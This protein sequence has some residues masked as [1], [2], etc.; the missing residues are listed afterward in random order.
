MRQFLLIIF[1]IA[2][3]ATSGCSYRPPTSII[4]IK[5]S[6][7]ML[8][9]TERLAEEFMKNNPGVSIYV[10]G[11][12]TTSGIRA[13]TRGQVHISTAS[14]KIRPEEIKEIAENYQVLGV[15]FLIAKDALSIYLNKNNPVRNLSLEQVRDIF[16]CRTNNWSALGGY[17]MAI[18]PVIRPPNSGT[19]AYIKKFVLQDE[20]YC[21]E[22][23]IRTSTSAVTET[24]A[25]SPGAIGYGG[26]AFHK[27]IEHAKING[28]APT[29]ENVRNDK[30]PLVRYLHFYTLNTPEGDVKKFIDWTLSPEG[31][32]IVKKSGYIPLWSIPF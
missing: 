15:S 1:S 28:Y 21:P 13:L 22:S 3:L 16:T 30:Y 31:Q 23:I 17:D 14:R 6:D 10:E 25:D 20:D 7:T 29:E 12:S 5:G 24:I 26:I 19:H 2:V 9:L 18:L 27:N 32:K 8:M 11:G 4:R